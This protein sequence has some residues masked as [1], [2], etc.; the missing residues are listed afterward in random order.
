MRRLSYVVCD[1]FT[2]VPLAGNQ[3]AVFTDGRDVDAETMQ[4]LAREMNFAESVFVLPPEAPD[5]DVRIRIFTPGTRAAVRRAPDARQR[6]RARGAAV[7]DRD[8]ARDRRRCRAGRARAGGAEDRL[9]ADGAAAAAVVAAP[10]TSRRSWP[11]SAS[12]APACRSSGTSSAR[13]TCTSSSTRRS[14]SPRSHPISRRC[15][16][17]RATAST[18][19]RATAPGGRRA[20]SRRRHGVVEDAATGSAAG[21]LA[22]HLARHGRIAFGEQIEISQG[23]EINRPSTLYAQ[24]DGSADALERVDGR[25]L[26]R[27]RRP[28]RLQASLSSS[29]AISGSSASSALQKRPPLPRDVEPVARRVDDQV[30]IAGEIA[31]ARPAGRPRPESRHVTPASCETRS[32]GLAST[33]AAIVEPA[34]AAA[35][36]RGRLRTGSGCAAQI[37]LPRLDLAGLE[38]DREGA[39]RGGGDRDHAA[40]HQRGHDAPSRGAPLRPD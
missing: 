23:A 17:R 30:G 6:V 20:C 32:G 7:E 11:R 13:A 2:D 33:T 5:A 22:V 1:V 9:R 15:S 36:T 25:R 19:S 24:A 28:R 34:A 10:R 3:L 21:P 14:R 35:T 27:R 37:V 31:T 40:G 39:V 16:A 4:A 18:A 29:A 38:I 26:G 8:P 12:S